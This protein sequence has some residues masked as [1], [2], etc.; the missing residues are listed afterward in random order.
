M[1]RLLRVPAGL[2]RVELLLDN[3]I[4]VGAGNDPRLLKLRGLVA[5]A[6]GKEADAHR[7]ERMTWALH[8]GL[9]PQS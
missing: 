4:S 6:L 7:F 9:L 1:G 8:P 3:A 5:R 2:Q